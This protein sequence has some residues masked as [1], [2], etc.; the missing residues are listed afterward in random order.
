MYKNIVCKIIGQ[1]PFLPVTVTHIWWEAFGPIWTHLE[2]LGRMFGCFCVWAT[3]VYNMMIT[4][5]QLLRY[6]YDIVLWGSLEYAPRFWVVCLGAFVLWRLICACRD[7]MR[8]IRYMRWHSI[9]LPVV[10]LGP[11]DN[12]IVCHCLSVWGPGM[13]GLFPWV[14]V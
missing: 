13:T 6:E 3:Y 4:E 10:A 2:V 14:L 8:Y 11:D 1:Y 9:V 7:I 5:T 12:L